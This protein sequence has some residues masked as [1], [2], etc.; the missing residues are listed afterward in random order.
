MVI[1]RLLIPFLFLTSIS[2]DAWIDDDRYERTNSVGYSGYS[3]EGRWYLAGS[4]ETGN[5]D[6]ELTSSASSFSY[7][8]PRITLGGVGPRAVRFEFSWSRIINE[9]QD[10]GITGLDGD[11][12]LPWEPERRIRPYLI[13]G[14]GYYQYYG[15]DSEFLLSND[16]DNGTRSL[17][18]GFAVLGNVSELTEMGI[19]LRYRFLT[20]TGPAEV[21]DKVPEADATLSSI[22]FRLQ[23]LF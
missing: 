3:G 4:L 18:L 8:A 6:Q 22:E 7:S 20:W 17:N 5:I 2:A 12:W 9:D 19:S 21:G 23:R 13:L 15:A 10:W 11:L 16:A 14:M 1:Q